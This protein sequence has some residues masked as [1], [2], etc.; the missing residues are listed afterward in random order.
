M[1]SV[2]FLILW[3]LLCPNQ[4]NTSHCKDKGCQVTTM[5]DTGG[6]T[7]NPPPDPPPPPPPGGG[8]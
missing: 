3:A 8:G 4:T 6:E 2:I 1:T 5:D 7:G